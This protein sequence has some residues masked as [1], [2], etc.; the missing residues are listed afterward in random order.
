[1][2]H[3]SPILVFVLGRYDRDTYLCDAEACSACAGRMHTTD[4]E[5]GRKAQ[6][7]VRARSKRE[8]G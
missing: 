5:N 8:G 7:K 1:M 4:E 2:I 6:R 3:R